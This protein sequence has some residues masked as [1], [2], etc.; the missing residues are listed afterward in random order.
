MLVLQRENIFYPTWLAAYIHGASADII[1]NNKRQRGL[2]AS[3]LFISFKQLLD[4]KIESHS[5][6]DSNRNQYRK[7]K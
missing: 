6:H 7:S 3:V 2:I 4:G 5:R 1:A